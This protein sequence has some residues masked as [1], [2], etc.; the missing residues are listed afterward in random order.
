MNRKD[1]KS[2]KKMMNLKVGEK[3]AVFDYEDNILVIN[4][5]K[6]ERIDNYKVIFDGKIYYLVSGNRILSKNK[7][8]EEL[9]PE[10]VAKL[11]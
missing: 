11:L 7:D 4:I 3:I 5:K 9:I 10:G 2:I 1:L 8:R 6:V